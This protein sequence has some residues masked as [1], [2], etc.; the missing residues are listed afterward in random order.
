[1]QPIVISLR[2][3]PVRFDAALSSMSSQHRSSSAVRSSNLEE[4]ITWQSFFVGGSKDG[5]K[6]VVPYGFSK[7]RA[8]TA[9]GPEFYTGGSWNCRVSAGPPDGPG[10]HA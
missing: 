2:D 4:Y 7:S 10:R 1:M 6:G 5:E 3:V 8:D 9:L